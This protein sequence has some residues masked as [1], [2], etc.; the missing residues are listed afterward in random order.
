MWEK[1]NSIYQVKEIRTKTTCYLGVGAIDKIDPIMERLSALGH[2]TVLVVSGRSSYRTC[3][4][5]VQ[6]A[7]ER[8]SVSYVHYDRITPNPTVDSVDEAVALAREAKATAVVAIG[9]GSPIDAAKSAAILMENPGWDARDLYQLKFVP[10]KAS[11]LVA[12]NLTH[13]TGTEVDRFA[14]VSI[15]EREY[16]PAIAYDC[17]YPM[18]AIDDPA[19]MTSLPAD[20]T[21]FVSID[22][23]NH[24]IEA[25]TTVAASP[26]SLLLARE[27]VRLV[28]EHLPRALKDPTDLEARYYLLYA[29]MIAGVAF[30]NGLL[31]LTHALEHPLS[32]VRPDLAHGLGLAM[33]VPAVVKNVYPA[34][35]HAL[36]EVLS[37]I[38]PG[39]KGDP[40][41]AMEAARAL[42]DWLFSVGVTSKLSQEGFGEEHIR[43]LVNLAKETPSLD[44][45]LALSPVEA[46]DQVIEDIYRTSLKPLPR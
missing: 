22:A 42:E 29:S 32:G 24:V 28:A 45:L 41:E 26:Y 14:V 15:P 5:K 46:T 13:G 38:A 33:I 16:K 44:T 40:S 31:H 3:W 27:T 10:E 12:I 21:R 43:K 17:I 20:Q 18:F 7:F 23:V 9:G 8:H 36:A 39:L 35:P 6:K 37:P 11:P 25:S 2:R 4:D 1:D 34:K 19:L 30:D